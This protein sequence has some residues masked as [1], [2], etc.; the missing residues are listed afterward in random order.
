[1]ARNL[2]RI[3]EPV[4]SM[5]QQKRVRGKTSLESSNLLTLVAH[6]RNFSYVVALVSPGGVPSIAAPVTL[7]K[8]LSCS[9]RAAL[10]KIGRTW[11]F[12]PLGCTWSESR[13]RTNVGRES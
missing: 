5:P 11:S 3:V 1:M 10:Q 13:S 8:R 4:Q 2:F 7:S 6:D 9:L 12:G